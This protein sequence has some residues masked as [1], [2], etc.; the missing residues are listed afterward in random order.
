MSGDEIVERVNEDRRRFVR[1]LV[2]GGAFAVPLVAS[3]DMTSLS[4]NS[5]FAGSSSGNQTSP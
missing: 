4:M 1:R 2:A 5:A 3:F